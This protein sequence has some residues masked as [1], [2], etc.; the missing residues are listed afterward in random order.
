LFSRWLLTR[1]YV[2]D[3]NFHAEHLKIKNLDSEVIIT[4][5]TGFFAEEKPYKDHLKVALETKEVSKKLY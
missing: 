4:D 2:L 5:G 3:G 1:G